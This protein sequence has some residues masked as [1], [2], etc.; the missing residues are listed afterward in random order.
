MYV[1]APDFNI[2]TAFSS[3]TG[4][5]TDSISITERFLSLVLSE[6]LSDLG[7][8]EKVIFKRQEASA[9]RESALKCIKNYLFKGI[10][11]LGSK[12]EGS[13]IAGLQSDS[14]IMHVLKYYQVIQS[15]SEWTHGVRNFLMIQDDTTSPGYCMLQ[16]L[17]HDV[18]LPE[19]DCPS[20]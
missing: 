16:L 5:M 17:R 7:V 1:L 18:P 14:D 2:I 13:T 12:A 8:N 15:T 4:K 19:T 11:R 10:Y 6:V 3:T 20:G 9:I